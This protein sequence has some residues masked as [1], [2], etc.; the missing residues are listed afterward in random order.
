MADPRS[1][2]V[3]SFTIIKGSLIDE[4]YAAFAA[5]DFS[6]TKLENLQRLEQRQHIGASSRNWARDVR[7]V[8]N[9]RFDPEGRDRPLVDP[10]AG[11][12]RPRGLEAAAALAHD[13]RRV[14][15]PRLP[16]HLALPAVR[17]RRVPPRDRGRRRLPRLARRARAT[18]TWSG[19]WT[20]RRR[21]RV[22][23][24]LLRI[25][26][27]LRPPDGRR[28][29]EFASYHLPDESFLYLLHAMR[30]RAERA[31]RHR[32]RPTGACTSWQRRRRARAPP[33]APVPPPRLRGGRQPRARS[34]SP[35][36]SP[37]AYAE[38]LVA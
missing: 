36:S 1:N 11:R 34:T 9:R 23:A 19:D 32:R 17:G 8:L 25:A 37:A 24:G 5:W 15:R 6:L 22:A 35:P 10:R 14:P 13:P 38:E 7:K 2:V 21:D 3:S 12:L 33:P 4:T 27:R 18:S 29:K 31:A 16:H 30:D 26:V 20:E 28:V